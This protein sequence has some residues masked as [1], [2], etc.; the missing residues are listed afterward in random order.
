ML[1]DGIYARIV[2]PDG[3]A[4]GNSGFIVLQKGVLVFDTHFTPEAGRELLEDIR[5]VTSKPV[6]YVVNSHYHPDHTHGNQAFPGAQVIANRGTREDILQ[7]DLPSLNR[8]IQ[9]AQSQ[10]ER[11]QSTAAK[12]TDPRR[13]ETLK[14]Q[15]RSQQE[16]LSTLSKLKIIPPFVVL[17]DYL[18]VQD[19][20]REVRIQFLGPGHTDTDTILYIPSERIV[21]CGDLFFKDAIPNVQDADIL[22]WM[23]TI[24]QILK[25]DADRFVPGHGIVGNRRDV[26]EFLAY[27]E[28]L[29]LLV[30]PYVTRG[31]GV[32]RAIGEIRVPAEY[33]G[34]RFMNFFR[35]NVQK[36]YAELKMLQLL[37]IPI[38]GPKKP[39]S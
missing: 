39:K 8:T 9:V 17:E 30:E 2:H 32:E 34:Y 28:G 3:N 33:S 21:F 35:A 13:L 37:S 10:L 36:M 20:F 38:E 16:Y 11:M 31:E 12:E 15:I 22:K 23:E 25:L 27:F 6:R 7:K 26:E 14:Q 18:S 19:G 4:V 24:K 1:T 5:T 29:R